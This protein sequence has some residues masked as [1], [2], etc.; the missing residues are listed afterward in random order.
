MLRRANDKEYDTVSEL[1]S[2][3]SS[4]SNEDQ[5]SYE[6]TGRAPASPELA[7]PAR[8]ESSREISTSRSRGRGRHRVQE[9]A[10]C[11]YIQCSNGAQLQ[12]L[13]GILWTTRAGREPS[14][15]GTAVQSLQ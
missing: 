11:Q 15:S 12:L 3:G 1:D 5:T 8:R 9:L 2:D 10:S 4:S 7:T 13:G 6:G 14:H